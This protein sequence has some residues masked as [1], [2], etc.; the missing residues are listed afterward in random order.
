MFV[1]FPLGR[2]RRKVSRAKGDPFI[3]I[4]EYCTLYLKFKTHPWISNYVSAKFSRW[5]LG[6]N[7]FWRQLGSSLEFSFWHLG[8]KSVWHQLRYPLGFEI[9]GYSFSGIFL[10]FPHVG[11]YSAYLFVWSYIFPRWVFT[12]L[13]LSW[14]T[15]LSWLSRNNIFATCNITQIVFG[16]NNHCSRL[17]W[18][19]QAQFS[20]HVL[21]LLE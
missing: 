14:G 19:Q 8:I 9:P 4:L 17:S 1:L 16:S 18:L 3:Q 13:L 10:C 12:V 6:I 21:M 5:H 15:T 7:S 20:I 11:V 2:L